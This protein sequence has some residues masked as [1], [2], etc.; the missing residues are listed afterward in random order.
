MQFHLASRLYLTDV[1]N[2]FVGIHGVPPLHCHEL[3]PLRG[4]LPP[5][6]L[7]WVL[8]G[9]NG[10][11]LA[12]WRFDCHYAHSWPF[13]FNFLWIQHQP[14]LPWH[15]QANLHQPSRETVSFF[16]NAVLAFG[17]FFYM[18]VSVAPLSPPSWG[19]HWKPVSRKSFLTHL[20]PPGCHRTSFYN[21][22]V[23]HVFTVPWNH[24]P[25]I[26]PLLHNFAPWQTQSSTAWETKTLKYS[27]R[28]CSGAKSSERIILTFLSS[29]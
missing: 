18:F 19:S 24:K 12:H 11:L 25:D 16:Y 14:V 1:F 26:V 5:S 9:H 13:L 20:P 17:C 8:T 28:G 3:P 4:P 29:L 23:I 6:A 10:F 22:F 15:S 7:P 2:G 21:C 27:Y